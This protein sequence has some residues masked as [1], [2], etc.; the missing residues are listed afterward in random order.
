MNKILISK[1]V[2]DFLLTIGLFLVLMDI[3]FI[4]PQWIQ[5]WAFAILLVMGSLTIINPVVAQMLKRI[6]LQEE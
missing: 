6:F 1:A 3:L 4:L 5:G 2:V